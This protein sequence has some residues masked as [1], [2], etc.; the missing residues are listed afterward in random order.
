VTVCMYVMSLD[1][2]ACLSLK[3]LPWNTNMRVL[4]THDV[5]ETVETLQRRQ[6]TL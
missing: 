5:E 3:Y 2:M 1:F 4:R 6:L